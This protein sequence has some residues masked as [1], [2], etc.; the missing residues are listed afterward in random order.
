MARAET[1]QKGL[2]CYQIDIFFK[3]PFS[4]IHFAWV[5]EY[6]QITSALVSL[7]A[8]QGCKSIKSP[9]LIQTFFLSLPGILAIL[10]FPSSHFTFSL[11]E[12]SICSITASTSPSFGLLVLRISSSVVS[13]SLLYRLSPLKTIKLYVFSA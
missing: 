1:S 7:W 4:C 6:L 10:S 8:I 3:Y 11:S 5:L 2:F 13:S 9:T 12:P